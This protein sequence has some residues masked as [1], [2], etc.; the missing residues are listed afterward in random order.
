MV[1][2][3]PGIETA[4]GDPQH[5]AQ[6]RNRVVGFLTLHKQKQ[7]YRV[8]LV[9]WAKKA[10]AFFN[11]SRSSRSIRISRCRRRN[12]SR[13][14]VVSPSR[15]P[16]SIS[17]CRIQLRSDCPLTSKSRATSAIFRFPSF[18]KRTASSLNSGGYGDV[19]SA[20]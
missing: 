9:S 5:A 10:A 3:T 7:L 15:C 19:F 11:I 16:S 12:S 1:P 4:G 17:C 8:L 13:S 14:E 20:S 6:V 2:P 18:T